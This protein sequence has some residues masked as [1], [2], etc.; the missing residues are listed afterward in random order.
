MYISPDLNSTSAPKFKRICSH[1][2]ADHFTLT[3]ASISGGCLPDVEVF[4][5]AAL[6]QQFFVSLG[7]KLVQSAP[8]RARWLF[9]IDCLL[10][11]WTACLICSESENARTPT[12]ILAPNSGHVL[13]LQHIAAW[14]GSEEFVMLSGEHRCQ[15]TGGSTTGGAGR[16]RGS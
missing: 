9:L 10:H 7:K 6:C 16:P 8:G 12:S 11:N 13:P 2:A 3:R 4:E 5:I 1:G 15:G 14:F